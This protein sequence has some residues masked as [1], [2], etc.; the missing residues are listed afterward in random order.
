MGNMECVTG[1]K[2]YDPKS[3]V[4]LHYTFHNS[5]LYPGE[6]IPMIFSSDSVSADEFGVEPIALLFVER[7]GLKDYGV[8]SQVVEKRLSSDHKIRAKIRVLQ[9][10]KLLTQLPTYPHQIVLLPHYSTETQ[11]NYVDVEILPEFHLGSPHQSDNTT[12]ALTKWEKNNSLA[13]RMKLFKSVSLPWPGFV[14]TLYDIRRIM[15]KIQY[16]AEELGMGECGI[17]HKIKIHF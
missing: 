3:C 2:F 4:R 5:V 9:R 14:Y 17:W 7:T 8:T 16:F 1:M 13:K 11:A 12:Y 6:I 15:M 10:F